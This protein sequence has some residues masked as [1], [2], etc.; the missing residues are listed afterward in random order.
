[1]SQP[2]LKNHKLYTTIKISPFILQEFSYLLN[3]VGEDER[4]PDRAVISL[5]ENYG[6]RISKQDVAFHQTDLRIA[7][8]TPKRHS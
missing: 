2:C 5:E 4:V 1:M 3:W 6:Q 7:Q 8:R